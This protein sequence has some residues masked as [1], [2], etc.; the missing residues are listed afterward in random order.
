MNPVRAAGGDDARLYGPPPG[1]Y[2][3]G[4]LAVIEQRSWRTDADL[5]EVYLAWSGFAY[6]RDRRGLA[7]PDA[8]R[9]RFAAIEVAVKNQDNREHDIFDSDDYLQDHGGMIAAV[10]GLTRHASPRPGSATPRIRRTRKVR[11]LAEEAARVVRSRVLNPEVDRRHAPS[12]LQGRVRIGRDRR[13][14]LRL[15][16]DRPRRRGL[17]V[18]TRRPRPTS[19]TPRSGSSSPS[20]NP[21][22]LRAIA[23]RLLE[24]DER[25]MWHA[26]AGRAA[27]VARRGARGRRMG[28]SPMSRARRVSVQRASSARTTP[29]WRCC[30]PSSSPASVACCCAARRVRPRP[31]SPAASPRCSPRRFAVRRTAA[32]RDRGSCHRHARHRGRGDRRRVALPSGPARR[33]ARRRAVRRRGQSARRPSRRHAARRRRLGRQHR[34]ARRRLASARRPVRA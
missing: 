31:P 24:A 4:I 20:S 21:W 13:L 34:R 6:G 30:S 2:G 12:R 5:A 32:G 27:G 8:M 26:S 17:D 18:R 23:E 16:R 10:R 9:R 11:S 7:A 1:G 15:R 19:A 28:G 22:A 3:S 33:R 29:S 14:S 25:G